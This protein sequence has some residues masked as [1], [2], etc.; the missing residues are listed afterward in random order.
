MSSGSLRRAFDPPTWLFV[1]VAADGFHV[2]G[3]TRQELVGRIFRTELRRKLFKDGE[4]ACE[5]RDGITG[6]DDIRC[7]DCRHPR[8][9]P[10]LRVALAAGS[11]RYVL[12]LASRSAQNLFA[13]EDLADEEDLELEDLVV[14]VTVT[15]HDSWGEV[16]F[17]RV[18]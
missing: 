11:V 8:C 17:E 2:D 16:C 3:K 14:R 5:S 4:L 9:R 12:D 10:M 15:S 13:L 7:D 1:R 18:R 6:K